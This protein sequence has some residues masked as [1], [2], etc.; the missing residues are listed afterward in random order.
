MNF[1]WEWVL[2]IDKRRLQR[3]HERF[4]GEIE[5]SWNAASVR[6]QLEIYANEMRSRKSEMNYHKTHKTDNFETV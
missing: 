6:A 1:Q 5:V 2:V 3:E 4:V